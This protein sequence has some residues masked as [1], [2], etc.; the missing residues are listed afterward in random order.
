MAAAACV[1]GWLSGL[2]AAPAATAAAAAAAAAA[3]LLNPR[4]TRHRQQEVTDTRTN[5]LASAG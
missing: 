1:A 5:S 2:L 4:D 3:G